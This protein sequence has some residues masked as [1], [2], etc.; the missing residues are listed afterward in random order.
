MAPGSKFALEGLVAGVSKLLFGVVLT[1]ERLKEFWV[2]V[3]E[4]DPPYPLAIIE[5]GLAGG[6]SGCLD[7]VGGLF[8]DALGCGAVGIV[9][10]PEKAGVSLTSSLTDAVSTVEA[11][12][13][14]NS[15]ACN[16]KL[17]LPRGVDLEAPYPPPPRPGAANRRPPKRQG[18]GYRPPAC[19]P[20]WCLGPASGRRRP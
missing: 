7:G 4:T 9:A 3:L 11:E 19:A 5:G 12:P 1:P 14:L 6:G 8:V 20:T 2:K 13:S 17:R 18:C 15:L 10:G 16:C